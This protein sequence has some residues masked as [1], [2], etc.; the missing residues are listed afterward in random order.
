MPEAEYSDI[1]P[2]RDAIDGYMRLLNLYRRD[3]GRGRV[4][5]DKLEDAEW[6]KSAEKYIYSTHD[7]PVLAR[8]IYQ[9]LKSYGQIYT[10]MGYGLKEEQGKDAV[11][12]T[13]RYIADEIYQSYKEISE[14]LYDERYNKMGG[15][16]EA[17]GNKLRELYTKSV[18]AYLFTEGLHEM[19]EGVK[20]YI[21]QFKEAEGNLTNNL[22]T[23]LTQV[24][25]LLDRFIKENESKVL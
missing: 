3:I 18:A 23:E 6:L 2:V 15:K 11:E 9:A 25:L 5:W 16:I 14:M 10:L 21:R 17:M 20:K 12:K 19:T 24:E 13:M 7:D 22:E 8:E 4:P 1:D